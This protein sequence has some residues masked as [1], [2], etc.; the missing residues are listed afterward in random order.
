MSEY[1][2]QVLEDLCVLKAQMEQL[3]GIGQPGRLHQL[4]RRVE[5]HERNMQRLKGLAGAFGGLLT[6]VHLLM[7]FVGRR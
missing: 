6:L 3:L 4:E 5:S 7:A 1:E 2:R